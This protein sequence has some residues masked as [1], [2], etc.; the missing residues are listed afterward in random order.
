MKNHGTEEGNAD[1]FASY[2]MEFAKGRKKN[3]LRR[4]RPHEFETGEDTLEKTPEEKQYDLLLSANVR[5]EEKNRKMEEMVMKMDTKIKRIESRSGRAHASTF[6]EFD[7]YKEWT[8]KTIDW[9]IGDSHQRMIGKI[10]KNKDDL[11]TTC[12][13][14]ALGWA[15]VYVVECA[16]KYWSTE[17]IIG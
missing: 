5:L 8:E 10:Q 16:L 3:T 11:A 13:H 12:K 4:W 9:K 6:H 7:G 15:V 14:I 2:F 1:L 17:K